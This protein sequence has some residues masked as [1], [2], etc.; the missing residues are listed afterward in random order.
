[1]FRFPRSGCL[2]AKSRGDRCPNKKDKKEN[3]DQLVKRQANLE[4]IGSTKKQIGL[5]SKSAEKSIS[6]SD[7]KIVDLKTKLTTIEKPFPI[8]AAK[9]DDLE[10][11]LDKIKEIEKKRAQTR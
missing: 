8:I 11:V 4:T 9:I 1:M 2:S 3:A 7:E 6:S 5:D 10:E